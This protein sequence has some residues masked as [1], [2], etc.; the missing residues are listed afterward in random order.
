M[1]VTMINKI[2]LRVLF[3][4]ILISCKTTHNFDYIGANWKNQ[5]IYELSHRYTEYVK[6]FNLGQNRR[7]EV[8]L[9]YKIE[10]IIRYPSN[11]SF[12]ELIKHIKDQNISFDSIVC[13][14]MQSNLG[15]NSEYLYPN[16]HYVYK[17][18]KIVDVIIFDPNNLKLIKTENSLSELKEMLLNDLQKTDGFERSLLIITTIKPNWSFEISK[19]IINN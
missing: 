2:H 13:V 19:I 16:Y 11:Y 9:F 1:M 4:C 17:N 7:S 10:E 15:S 6:N 8:D 14:S 5:A 3:C 18:N 12:Q